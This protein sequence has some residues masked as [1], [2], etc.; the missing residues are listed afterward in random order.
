MLVILYAKSQHFVEKSCP[1][2]AFPIRV[3]LGV[4]DIPPRG[5]ETRVS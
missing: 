5:A 3:G 1:P 2:G 4:L